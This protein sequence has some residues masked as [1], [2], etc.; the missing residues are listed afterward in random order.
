MLCVQPQQILRNAD[1]IVGVAFGRQ[2]MFCSVSP[3]EDG[4]EHFFCAGLS[5]G[6]GQRHRFYRETE[7]VK[8][9]EVLISSDRG[10]HYDRG[11]SRREY[12]EF[13]PLDAEK[14]RSLFQ[15]SFQ[16]VVTIE[17]FAGNGDE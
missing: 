11:S 8:T 5:A 9:G 3:V 14:R 17:L 6:S 10:I 15:S 1:L 12:G 13:F 2:N 7:P 16:K 4:A